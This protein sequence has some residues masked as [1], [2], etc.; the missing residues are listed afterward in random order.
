V[1]DPA[2]DFVVAS[3]W[4]LKVRAVEVVPA[5]LRQFTGDDIK[6]R[7]RIAEAARLRARL[8]H[9]RPL[10]RLRLR[11]EL[12]GSSA[13]HQIMDLAVKLPDKT[14]ALRYSSF[15]GLQVLGLHAIEQLIRRLARRRMLDRQ[16]RERD[17]SPASGLRTLVLGDQPM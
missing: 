15:V 9:R 8:R 14:R 10:L 4:R 3:Q 5:T 12:V 1:R 6:R 16:A 2:A 17:V 11:A 13:V 7:N